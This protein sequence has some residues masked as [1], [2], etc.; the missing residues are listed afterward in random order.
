M[1]LQSFIIKLIENFFKN[2]C[3]FDFSFSTKLRKQV[4]TGGISDFVGSVTILENKINGTRRQCPDLFKIPF[5]ICIPRFLYQLMRD[6][7]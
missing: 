4:A 3:K 6:F 1:T 5:S 7:R 2:L